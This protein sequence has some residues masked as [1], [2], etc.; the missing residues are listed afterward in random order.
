MTVTD[1]D[2]RDQ[3]QLITDA[4]EGEYDVE[5]LTAVLVAQHDLTGDHPAETLDGLDC[6]WHHA[7]ARR[8]ES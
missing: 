7:L 6:F 4:Q 5:G 2:I 8:K 1:R 3:V